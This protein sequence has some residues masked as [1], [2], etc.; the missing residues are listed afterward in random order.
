M[1]EL[2]TDIR[3][4]LLRNVVDYTIVTINALEQTNEELQA[5]NA[6]LQELLILAYSDVISMSSDPKLGVAILKELNM[7]NYAILE[8][9]DAL[10]GDDNE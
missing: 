10:R 3:T 2:P 6:K 9:R 8:R 4:E 1:N 5:N 7:T